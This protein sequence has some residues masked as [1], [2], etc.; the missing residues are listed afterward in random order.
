MF[1]RDWIPLKAIR[2]N[3][4]PSLL[5]PLVSYQLGIDVSW[6]VDVMQNDNSV[7]LA[8]LGLVVSR[9][10]RDVSV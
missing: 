4:L 9:W 7:G 2:D 1:H 3:N 6:T 10:R 5:G 8:S